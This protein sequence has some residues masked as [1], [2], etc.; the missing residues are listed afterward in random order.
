MTFFARKHALQLCL[1]CSIFLVKLQCAIN[2]IIQ[3]IFCQIFQE[4]KLSKDER[5]RF[6]EEA[7]M[8]KGLQHPNIVRFYDSWDVNRNTAKTTQL[9]KKYIVLVSFFFEKIFVVKVQRAA[10][11]SNHLTR[12][13]LIVPFILQVTELMTSGTLKTYLKRFKKINQRVLKSW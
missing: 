1:E 3:R 10:H 5:K 9:N 12:K 8:L 11:K 2:S 7:E 13:S 4:K 6:R